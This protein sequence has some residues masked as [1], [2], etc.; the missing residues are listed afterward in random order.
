MNVNREIKIEKV[1]INIG[2]G[3]DQKILENAVKLIEYMTGIPPVKTKASKRIPA[4]G[5]RPGLPIG[6]K[7][8]LRG[9]EKVELLKKVLKA[10]VGKIKRTNFDKEGNL[11]MGVHEYIDVP[12]IKY[13]PD[14]ALIGFQICVT[15][16]RNGYRIKHRRIMKKKVPMNHKVTQDDAIEYMKKEFNITVEEK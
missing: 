6:C 10:K 7:L 16:K 12:D 14:I 3:K 15:F 4:W 2:A 1:T 11:A 13:N 8:T 9:P 5:L